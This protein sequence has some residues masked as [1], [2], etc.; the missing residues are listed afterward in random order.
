ML[1]TEALRVLAC[2]CAGEILSG[3]GLLPFPG[4]VIGLVFL[5]ANLALIGEVPQPLGRLADHVLAVLGMLFV[6]TGVG[7]LAYTDLLRT[8]FAPIAAA[9]LGGTLVTIVVT[10][11]AAKRL[12]EFEAQKRAIAEGEATDAAA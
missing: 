10:A 4:P 11:V 8:E 12:I 9:I 1:I 2:L 5:L 6:P 3:V 7:L